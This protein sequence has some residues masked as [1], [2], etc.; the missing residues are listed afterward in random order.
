MAATLY[1]PIVKTFMP[2]FDIT[3]GQVKINFALSSYNTADEIIGA[4]TRVE[5]TVR[6]QSNN[7]NVLSNNPNYGGTNKINIHSAS[8]NEQKPTDDDYHISAPYYIIISQNEFIEGTNFIKDAFYKVQLRFA[9]GNG[10][11]EWSTVCLIKPIQK[12]NIEIVNFYQNIQSDDDEENTESY[13]TLQTL[14]PDFVLSY[15]PD[16]SEETLKYWRMQLYDSSG[17]MVA[18]TGQTTVNKYQQQAGRIAVTGHLKYQMTNEAEYTL[19]VSIETKNG[20]KESKEEKFTALVTTSG[21]INGTIEL[22]P[23][24]EEGYNKISLRG[25]EGTIVHTNITLRRASSKTNFLVWEDIANITLENQQLNWDFYDF[26]VESGVFYQYGAQNRDNRGRRS[27]L[28]KTEK[29]LMDFENA[30]LT[31]KSGSIDDAIQLKIK[32]D[33]N[34]ANTVINVGEA[35]TDTIGSKYPFIRRNGNMYYKSFP[36][37]FLITTYTDDQQIFAKYEEL[38]DNEQDLYTI[39]YGGDP[40]SVYKGHY[41]YNYEKRF[42]DKVEQFLYNN[43]VKLFRSSTQGNMLIKL[44]NITLTPKQELGRLLYSVDATAIQIDEVTLENLDYYG[45]QLIGDYSPKI[46]FGETLI[47]QINNFKKQWKRLEIPKGIIHMAE[48]SSEIADFKAHPKTYLAYE[49]DENIYIYYE[50][51]WCMVAEQTDSNYIIFAFT[52]VE[53][54]FIAGQNL[55]GENGIFR[56]K[57]HWHKTVD[58]LKT[59]SFYLSYLRIE[60][61][62][63]PYLIDGTTL[64]PL[65]DREKDNN[66]VLDSPNSKTILGTIIKIG[67]TPV[68]IQY[69]NTIYELKGDNVYID[70][71]WQITPLKNTKML[72]DYTIN[73]SE[74]VDETGIVATTLKYKKINGQL[75][76]T[77]YPKVSIKSMIEQKY[78][79]NLWDYSSDDPLA[80]LQNSPY[81]LKINNF[82][83]VNIEAN[84]G[85]IFYAQTNMD[86]VDMARKFIIDESGQLFI[87]PDDL[88]GVISILYFYG[89]NIDRRKLNFITIDTYQEQHSYELDAYQNGTEVSI[90]H[91]GIWYPARTQDNGASYEISC[92][93]DAYVYYYIQTEQGFY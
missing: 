34:V 59:V 36:F 38:R 14:Q 19:K 12:P 42:R 69:P 13:F 84:P 41:D 47:G 35:K 5:Y 78:F 86:N 91:N 67:N 9:N 75:A 85:T 74:E 31:Q 82:Y 65:D 73:L 53:E 58:R 33:M 83:N 72:I 66:N 61:N 40:F 44:M 81:Y 51:M 56:K 55:M 23:N 28:L 43:K 30:F 52:L 26:T 17:T 24:Y 88:T 77:F 68:V 49:Q 54:P 27:T 63:D 45:I 1:P 10:F 79:L 60:I 70:Q 64:T 2:A 37:S 89:L 32:Y 25:A 46:E 76:R 11:S 3:D 16:T 80:Q 6:Y 48:S 50:D 87:D 20:Y 39:V 4:N 93:V 62:S 21:M 29:E 90:F 71:N 15:D 8:I 18:D 57:Y 22:Y 92:P 7:A